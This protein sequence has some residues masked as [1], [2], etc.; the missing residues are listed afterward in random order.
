[1]ELLQLRYFLSAA[2]TQNFTTTAN[3]YHVPVSN[4]SQTIK[5]L[6][7]ELGVRLFDRHGNRVRINDQGSAFYAHISAAI[8]SIDEGIAAVAPSSGRLHDTLHLL[9]LSN[10]DLVSNCISRFHRLYPDVEVI[11]EH[12]LQKVHLES[13]DLIISGEDPALDGFPKLHL[14]DE[15]FKIAVSRQTLATLG[16]ELTLEALKKANYIT[17]AKSKSFDTALRE[18]GKHFHFN[19]TVAFVCEDP[20]YVL[21]Y[22]TDNLGIAYI[23]SKTWKHR[24]SPD[25]VLLPV[26][27][28]ELERRTYLYR[29]LNR[30][31]SSAVERFA[32]ILKDVSESAQ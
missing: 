32:K 25:I 31:D 9:A 8:A 6:E 11:F 20:F 17:L 28:F 13:V 23:P 29:N 26:K 10:R 19:P 30:P 14:I 7:N 12:N 18:L 4:I 21:K 15:D 16:G 27:G 22:V 3:I 5:K 1:M 2:K 24:M